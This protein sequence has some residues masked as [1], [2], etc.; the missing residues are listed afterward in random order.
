MARCYE[1]VNAHSSAHDVVANS[2]HER[3]RRLRLR[4]MHVSVPNRFQSCVEQKFV[5]EEV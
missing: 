2:V 3:V 5:V 4:E 1:C